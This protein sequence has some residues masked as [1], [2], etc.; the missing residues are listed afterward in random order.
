MKKQK[1][2]IIS[3]ILL[4]LVISISSLIN[5]FESKAGYVI[6]NLKEIDVEKFERKTENKED[7]ILYVYGDTCKYCEI[8][9]PKL[10]K[11]LKSKDMIAYKYSSDRNDKQFKFISEHLEDKFQGTPA[12]YFYENGKLVDYFIGDE[13][14][15][16]I[17]I[18]ID[19]YLQNLS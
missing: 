13:D 15:S 11:I 3:I 5:I 1:K 6:K 17:N 19:K 9:S 8:F 4:V 16:K 7:F 2:I 10:D 18:Y 12:I 14:K